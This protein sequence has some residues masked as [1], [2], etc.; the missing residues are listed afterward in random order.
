MS[1]HEGCVLRLMLG[2]YVCLCLVCRPAGYEHA[3]TCKEVCDN[4]CAQMPEP[5][6]KGACSRCINNTWAITCMRCS[7]TTYAGLEHQPCVCVCVCVC[8]RTCVRAVCLCA[9]MYLPC[10]KSSCS[11]SLSLACVSHSIFHC[12]LCRLYS[13][14]ALTSGAWG[15]WSAMTSVCFRTDIGVRSSWRMRSDSST[16]PLL[17]SGGSVCAC[18][19]GLGEGRGLSVSAVRAA[20]L[21][22]RAR[23]VSA[24]GLSPS[25]ALVCRLDLCL[26]RCHCLSNCLCIWWLGALRACCKVG[27]RGWAHC[28]TEPSE[29]DPGA[30]GAWTGS[31]TAGCT[32]TCQPCEAPA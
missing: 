10:C 13:W 27:Q 5:T 28:V 18:G 2:G 12:C 20:Q 23:K 8:V 14:L 1:N 25:A 26:A 29:S 24:R 15:S 6:R 7:R 16:R 22:R 32:G 21:V 4:A 30:L 17:R 9:C 11:F 31:L 3:T 19:S